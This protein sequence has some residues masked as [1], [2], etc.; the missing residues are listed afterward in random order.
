VY[1][2][3][4]RG[5]IYRSD[6][7]DN[8]IKVED[9]ANL[10]EGEGADKA[11]G[12][13]RVALGGAMRIRLYRGEKVRAM[14]TG[15]QRRR[16][17][18]EADFVEEEAATWMLLGLFAQDRLLLVPPRVN[19]RLNSGS[20]RFFRDLLTLGADAG[21]VVNFKALGLGVKEISNRT[22]RRVIATPG[23]SGEQVQVLRV[24]YGDR[25][26]R[27]DMEVAGGWWGEAN[28][29]TFADTIRA[30]RTSGLREIVAQRTTPFTR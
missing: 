20:R 28:A 8:F 12:R 2:Y 24:V 9:L 15:P 18:W 21:W 10:V 23:L 5:R 13:V 19:E 1:Q 26:V 30:V 29:A 11:I 17:D 6:D 14:I 25:Q 3:L 4:S 27:S 16:I 7:N 22:V